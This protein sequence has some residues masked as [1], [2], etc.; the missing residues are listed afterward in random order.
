MRISQQLRK[1][2][3]WQDF[4][5]LC[6]LLW[7][8]EWGS[9]DLKLNGRQGQKQCGVDIC[10]HR[11][12]QSGYCGI[13][14]K[15]KKDGETLR[16]TEIIAE[17][18]KAKEFNPRLKHLI[19]ATTAEKDADVEE[20]VRTLDESLRSEGWFSLDIKSWEDIVLLL[21]SHKDVLKHYLDITTDQYDVS[22]KFV[23]DTDFIERD[24]VF[25]RTSDTVGLALGISSIREEYK[26][27]TSPFVSSKSA[28]EINLSYV[29]IPIILKNLGPSPLDDYKMKFWFDE[30]VTLATKVE[31]HYSTKNLVCDVD[32][33]GF[34][35]AIDK[36]GV[37]Y[38]SRFTL[39]SYDFDEIPVFY[40]KPHPGTKNLTLHWELLSRYYHTTGILR[41]H[42]KETIHELDGQ[43][44]DISP[45]DWRIVDCIIFR[46]KDGTIILPEQ[47]S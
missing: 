41:I 1:P 20:Y 4:E 47:T 40:A 24:V 46:D 32:L 35:L 9:D 22:V 7:R 43:A 31:T 16:K 3:H 23:G 17:V 37:E 42:L 10:G 26:Y 33:S 19:V 14:C 27:S 28:T 5:K 38:S 30:E 29:K 13:Q 12:S 34:D 6:L 18:E 44:K 2:S 11:G 8:A 15:C 36:G 21:E 25:F 45:E 39:V